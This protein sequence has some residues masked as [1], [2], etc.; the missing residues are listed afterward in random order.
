ML[1]FH[2]LYADD[3]GG[4]EDDDD[5]ETEDDDPG[6][7]RLA[8]TLRADGPAPP[9]REAVLYGAPYTG[10]EVAFVARDDENDPEVA[11]ECSVTS[12]KPAVPQWNTGGAQ[13]RGRKHPGGRSRRSPPV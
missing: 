13:A 4:E 10:A 3:D 2:S 8:A 5:F 1:W 7:E 11:V 12:V 6:L 9:L